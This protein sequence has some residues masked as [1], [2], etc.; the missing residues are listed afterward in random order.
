MEEN[1]PKRN[2]LHSEKEKIDSTLLKIL[3][4][5]LPTYQIALSRKYI[6]LERSSR[7]D[8]EPC[9]RG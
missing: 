2:V 1:P 9:P 4:N 8:K 3:Y 7:A 5:E 6:A